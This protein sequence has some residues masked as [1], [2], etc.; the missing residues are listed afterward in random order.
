MTK[1]NI[2]LICLTVTAFTFTRNVMADDM[3]PL[4]AG[5][6]YGTAAIAGTLIASTGLM[7]VSEL[8]DQREQERLRQQRERATRSLNDEEGMDYTTTSRRN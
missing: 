6:A 1:K 4:T 8:R 2:L 7:S 3:D 5:V